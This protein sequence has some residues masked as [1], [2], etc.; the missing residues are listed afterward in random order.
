MSFSYHSNAYNW[1]VVGFQVNNFYSYAAY[2]CEFD[3]R[4][5]NDTA[6]IVSVGPGL[7]LV[8]KSIIDMHCKLFGTEINITLVN[9]NPKC[10]DADFQTVDD[11]IANRSNIV[12]N[13]VLLLIWPKGISSISSPE[14]E[15]DDD[16]EAVRKLQPRA[17]L[18]LYDETSLSI[19]GSKGFRTWLLSLESKN[20]DAPKDG[21][22]PK[23][24]KYRIEEAVYQE[25]RWNPREYSLGPN[26][27]DTYRPDTN[28]PA[29][30]LRLVKLTRADVKSTKKPK[31]DWPWR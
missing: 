22:R 10:D 4:N 6:E 31:T 26:K 12:K 28:K 1:G 17:L 25:V 27:N 14:G 18:T 29:L 16:I 13:C 21:K 20:Y 24:R 19:S 11:L 3:S 7:G 15:N 23:L 5:G 2:F 8:E 9:N 30:G